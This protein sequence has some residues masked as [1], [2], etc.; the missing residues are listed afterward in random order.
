MTTDPHRGVLRRRRGGG[1]AQLL[2]DLAEYRRLKALADAQAPDL[3]DNPAMLARGNNRAF[4]M[5]PHARVIGAKL[6]ELEE[7]A[8]TATRFQGIIIT[9]PPQVGKSTL[10]T[11]WGAFWW[12]AL[13]PRRRVLC[14]CYGDDLAVRR[15][16]NTQN[17][18]RAHGRP[19]GVALRRGS[20]SVKDWSL[21]AGGGMRSVGIGS[22]TT[23]FDADRLVIDDPHKDRRD[24]QSKSKRD[25]VWDWWSSTGSTRL[26]P[27]AIVVIVLTRWHD[28][29]IAGRV[30]DQQGLVSEGGRWEL[31]HIPGFAD[32]S[33]G[34]DP[35]G[36]APGEPLPHPK[37]PMDNAVA[38]RDHWEDKKAI[39]TVRDFHALIQGDPRP[40]EGALM[41]EE[42]LVAIRA[43]N[44]ADRPDP[45]R[46]AVAVDP[47]G[48]GRDVA[49]IIGGFRGEDG[50]LWITHDR[51][52]VMSSQEWA[53]EACILAAEIDAS[54][55]ILEANYG[56]DMTALAVRATWAQLREAWIAEHGTADGCP[57]SALPPAVR[58]EHARVGK[59][60]RAEPVAQQML[61]D[62]VRLAAP[63]PYL[64]HEWATWQPDD[65]DSPGRIDA[66]VYLAYH[67]L[68]VPGA[69]TL[70]SPAK[71]SR[72]A[73]AGSPMGGARIRR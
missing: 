57:F 2:A 54:S 64:E 31:L 20:A 9:T 35:L 62:K 11:E 19:Y 34:E 28:D 3:L 10:V 63:L 73:A 29:D 30:I 42:L 38:L 7:R 48:G 1:D 60:L 39:M 15:G 33:F 71:I 61:V 49:G 23:G 67:L 72:D 66:S 59:L 16:T 56:G 17:L 32:P 25:A 46:I 12:L 52:G 22:G 53:R 51:S 58:T 18:V 6:A 40:A 37:I 13:D 69:S 14:A 24:A 55:I 21:T 27:H 50:R 44:P 68:Q 70:I 41:T 45:V 4:L 8:R 65:P 26:Q 43:W 47:S 36:R 5:R